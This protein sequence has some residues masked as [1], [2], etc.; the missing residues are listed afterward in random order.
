M[1]GVQSPFVG[2]LR[3][4][5]PDRFGRFI[6]FCNDSSDLVCQKWRS[7][8]SIEDMTMKIGV[9]L[10]NLLKQQN[11]SLRELSK[12]SGVPYTTLQEWTGN[13]NPKNSIQ[14]RKVANLLGVSMHFLLFGEE[15]IHEPLTKLLKEDLFSGT[16]EI[17]IKKVRLR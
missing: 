7:P 5:L 6:V 11:L 14:V 16:F 3:K 2:F 12:R 10:Q 9:T 4:P 17:T 15:D 1:C 13:R 8:M